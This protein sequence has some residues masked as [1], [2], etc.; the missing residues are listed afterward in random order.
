[1]PQHGTTIDTKPGIEATE[2][3]ALP[4]MKMSFEKSV[5]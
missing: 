4:A 5:Y 2:I 1:M 3:S